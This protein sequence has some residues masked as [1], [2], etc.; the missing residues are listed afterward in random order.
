MIVVIYTDFLFPIK[1]MP[2]SYDYFDN[3]LIQNWQVWER[4]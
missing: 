3:I 2:Y 4:P 1:K